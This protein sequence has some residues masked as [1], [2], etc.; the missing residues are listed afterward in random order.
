MKL[1]QEKLANKL[2]I[3]RAI[4]NKMGKW[5]IFFP[6]IQNLIQLSEIFKVTIDRLVKER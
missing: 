5:T 4:Y 1:S 3:S 6:D 2:H